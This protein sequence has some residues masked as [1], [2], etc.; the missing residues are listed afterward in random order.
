MRGVR[1]ALAPLQGWQNAK[2][3][4]SAPLRP[5]QAPRPARRFPPVAKPARV[6]ELA[7]APGGSRWLRTPRCRHSRGGPRAPSRRGALSVGPTR[8]DGGGRG[9]GGADR[10]ALRLRRL[11]TAQG[12]WSTRSS[13][14][15]GRSC[16]CSRPTPRPAPEAGSRPR[17]RLTFQ[18]FALG[19]R[20]AGRGGRR[21]G[22]G[23]QEPGGVR[24]RGQ[25]GGRG[26]QGRGG[27]SGR[28]LGRGEPW[29]GLA[30]LPGT[31]LGRGQVHPQVRV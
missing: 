8:R 31:T 7:A 20:W 16:A 29:L 12:S 13:A 14:R 26:R 19:F 22:W 25:R 15:C 9:P 24:P 3:R 23:P 17:L 6:A 30:G 28:L 27:G 1:G 18:E 2:P 21:L 5:T 10:T 4:R 11:R